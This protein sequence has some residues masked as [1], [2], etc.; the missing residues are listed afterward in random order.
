MSVSKLHNVYDPR[1]W[2][3]TF[4]GV[5]DDTTAWTSLIAHLA[6]QAPSGNTGLVEGSVVRCPDGASLNGVEHTLPHR[7]TIEGQGH[8]TQL[9]STTD[10][11]GFFNLV[12][13]YNHLRSLDFVAVNGAHNLTIFRQARGTWRDLVFHQPR[14]DRPCVTNNPA[15]NGVFSMVFDF[16]T[17]HHDDPVAYAYG[18][19]GSGTGISRP[20]FEFSDTGAEFNANHLRAWNMWTAGVGD[21]APAIRISSTTARTHNNQVDALVGERCTA[22]LLHLDGASSWVINNPSLHDTAG[23]A[24]TDHVIKFGQNLN[25]NWGS[26]QNVVAGYDRRDGDLDPSVADIWMD[27]LC[28]ETHIVGLPERPNQNYVFDFG[29]SSGTVDGFFPEVNNADFTLL[30][31]D[32][33]IA[34]GDGTVHRLDTGGVWRALD[35]PTGAGAATWV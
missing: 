8:A 12:G 15:G 11:A 17:F 31:A 1:D 6:A 7:T 21:T 22:G 25:G 10:G 14:G 2:G 28:S 26:R 32:N 23:D 3:V 27:P 19:V 33:V 20:S 4:D 34:R 29:G 16:L 30:N 13:R 35:R 5:T 18:G 9:V 24:I